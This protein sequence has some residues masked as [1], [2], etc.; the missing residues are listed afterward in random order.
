MTEIKTLNVDGKMIEF[1]GFK[2]LLL[3]VY[4]Y[5]R[6]EFFFT[7]DT[8]YNSITHCLCSM[9]EVG[10]ELEEISLKRRGQ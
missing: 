8:L 2:K 7:L 4:T 5:V 3:Q 9:V 10:Y 1:H 6:I